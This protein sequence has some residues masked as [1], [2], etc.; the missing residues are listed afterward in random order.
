MV[1]Y[2]FTGEFSILQELAHLGPYLQIQ[3]NLVRELTSMIPQTNNTCRKLRVSA[4]QQLWSGGRGPS[5]HGEI[6]VG[7]KIIEIVISTEF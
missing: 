4:F 7:R 3:C 1:P 5:L 2:L 6:L